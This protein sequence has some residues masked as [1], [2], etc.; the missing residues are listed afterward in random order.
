VLPMS[1]ALDFGITNNGGRV[2]DVAPW[3]MGSRGLVAERRAAAPRSPS[4]PEGG[5]VHT[6]S[7]VTFARVFD[8]AQL[9]KLYF[10]NVLVASGIEKWNIVSMKTKTSI[11]IS[12]DLLKLIDSYVEGENRRSAFIEEAVKAYLEV[13]KR[14]KRDR[15]DLEIINRLSDKLNREADDVLTFQKR[16]LK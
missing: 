10:A 14:H 8:Q 3:P 5:D 15:R 13:L 4:R 12:D 11:T 2:C 6:R 16:N 1:W 7:Y 9:A